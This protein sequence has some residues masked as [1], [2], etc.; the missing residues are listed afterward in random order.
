MNR[1]GGTGKDYEAG[2]IEPRE[3]PV[4]VACDSRGGLEA[5]DRNAAVDD[6][7]GLARSNFIEERA[8]P[9]LGLSD[10]RV[11]YRAIVARTK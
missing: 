9:V 3:P 5:R 1:L 7:D 2:A 11:S 10:G 4:I 8:Q 6:D